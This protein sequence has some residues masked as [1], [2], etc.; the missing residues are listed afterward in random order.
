MIL[1][2]FIK[3]QFRNNSVCGVYCNITPEGEKRFKVVQV[4]HKKGQLDFHISG[5][6][7]DQVQ[8]VKKL[9]GGN[10]VY[11][12]ID[13]KGILLRTTNPDPDQPLIR[14]IIPTASEEEFVT[15]T[16]PGNNAVHVAIAR[17]DLVDE[18][19]K[20]MKDAG[21]TVICLALGPYR[22]ANL[23]AYFGD[24]PETISFENNR[25]VYDHASG[26][27]S[28][29]ERLTQPSAS[30][31]EIDK[32]KT[33]GSFLP[34]IAVA[35]EYFL[36]ED[37]E[38]NF[39]GIIGQKKEFHSRIIYRRAGMGVLFLILTVL[40]VNMFFYMHYQEK[41]QQMESSLT[42][43]RKILNEL[44]TLKKEVEWK[45]K[46]MKESGISKDTKMAFYADRI[47]ATVPG[48]ITLDRMEIQPLTG[49]IRSNKEITVRPDIIVLAGL[50][51]NSLYLNDWVHDLKALKWVENVTIISYL[52]EDAINAGEFSVE[53]N[54]KK[55][56]P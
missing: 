53:L 13:G 47:A 45:Q 26:M 23:S 31:Y 25:I 46:F 4:H 16:Y 15:D 19:W 42:G 21:I 27:I 22:V 35:F 29:F 24:F 43:S 34:A 52:Q 36:D 11:L 39:P 3:Y 10:P 48:E 6:C 14:Q 50:T 44:D 56:K 51:K 1:K 17:K 38:C 20:Q 54:I 8:E 41:T 32:Q 28:Q 18:L 55:G 2:D 40:L 37:R 30:I 5:E 33:D 12:V 7:K 9:T 49:K